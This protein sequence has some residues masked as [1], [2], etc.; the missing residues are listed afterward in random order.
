MLKLKEAKNM[1]S[2]SKK[3][4]AMILVIDR[5]CF[6]FLTKKLDGGSG[7]GEEFQDRSY[8]IPFSF[9]SEQ[10]EEGLNAAIQSFKDMAESVVATHIEDG[11]ELLFS[12]LETVVISAKEEAVAVELST[13]FLKWVKSFCATAHTKLDMSF[14]NIG[15]VSNEERSEYLNIVAEAKEKLTTAV[16]TAMFGS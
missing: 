13:A 6:D 10:H 14:Y 12:T 11:E 7:E 16:V 2:T 15:A 4:F 3:N 9:L 1:K 5:I 8:V